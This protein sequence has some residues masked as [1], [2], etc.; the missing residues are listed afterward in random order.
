MILIIFIFLFETS[1]FFV[2]YF[3]QFSFYPSRLVNFSRNSNP[4][5]NV[6]LNINFLI[7]TKK[8]SHITCLY[9]VSFDMI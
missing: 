2:E 6:I 9:N 5:F 8:Q 4:A 3:R 7:H 1:S